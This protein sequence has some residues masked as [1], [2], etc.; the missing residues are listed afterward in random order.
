[1]TRRMPSDR[2]LP[3]R[4]EVFGLT[5]ERET[6]NDALVELLGMATRVQRPR[7]ALAALL[8]LA[9]RGVLP[10]DEP[11]VALLPQLTDWRAFALASLALGER[12]RGLLRSLL[13]AGTLSQQQMM[14]GLYVRARTYEWRAGTHDDELSDAVLDLFVGSRQPIE[15]RFAQELRS[16][17][18]STRGQPAVEWVLGVDPPVSNALTV[19]R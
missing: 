3:T 8:A 6:S 9:A 18:E 1:M 5:F 2:T 11:L 7:T 16:F 10:G 4:D 12:M 14:I 13:A 15:R 17:V 19:S